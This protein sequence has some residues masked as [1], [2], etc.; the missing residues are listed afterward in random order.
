VAGDRSDR[1]AAESALDRREEAARPSGRQ[2]GAF[3]RSVKEQEPAISGHAEGPRRGLEISCER[4][5][6]SLLDV[7]FPM[8]A[9][10]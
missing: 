1:L 4:W 8:A 10:E 2:A 3:T 7:L 9:A 5:P 6:T